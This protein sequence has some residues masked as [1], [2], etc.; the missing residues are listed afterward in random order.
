MI[1]VASF[2]EL[3]SLIYAAAMTPALWDEAVLRIH[4]AFAGPTVNAGQVRSTTLTFADGVSRSMSGTLSP[5]ADRAYGEHFGR[6]DQPLQAVERGTVGVLRTGS[7]LIAPRRRT[8]FYADWLRPNDLCDGIFVRLTSGVKPT[9]FVVAGSAARGEFDSEVRT[10]L[11]ALLIPHFQRALRIQGEL[12]TM[13]Q[14][15][16][17]FTEALDTVDRGIAIVTSDSR[18]AH[19]NAEAVQILRK[20]DGLALRSQC[21]VASAATARQRFD[22]LLHTALH[23]D[24]DG[25]RSGGSMSCDRP[26][27]R[28]PF[29]VHIVPLRLPGTEVAAHGPTA[30]VVII[31][32]ACRPEPADEALRRL[33]GLTRTE[34]AVAR[35]VVS[36]QGLGPIGEQLTLSRDTVKTHLRSIFLKTDT[37]RQAE[38][39]RLLLA[40][41][42]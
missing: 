16:D 8:E 3:V 19:V 18:V 4:N 30:K 27:G 10:R 21:I 9:C 20:D 32:P 25:V 38:L 13:A 23:G 22:G 1:P 14:Q 7:E 39:V 17:Q 26:S 15:V 37:H 42:V 11:M 31:D 5:D 2:S 28:R 41:T 34:A 6:F 24:A 12:S 36:G 33:F 29:A 40:V 35:L